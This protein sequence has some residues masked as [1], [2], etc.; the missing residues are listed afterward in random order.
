[1]IRFYIKQILINTFSEWILWIIRLLKNFRTYHRLNIRICAGTKVIQSQ[2][3]GN[4]YI[5]PHA[6]LNQVE[7]GRFSY[8]AHS[9]RIS[10]AQIGRFCSIGM[11]VL[12]GPGRHPTHFISSHPFF[13]S[14]HHEANQC[15]SHDGG[16][17][18]T[19]RVTIGHDVWIGAKCI[20]LDGV[21]IGHG[22]IIA[23]GA[24]VTKDIPPYTIAAGIPAKPFRT[25]FDNEKV[26]QLLK[27]PWWDKDISEL[28]ALS[29]QMCNPDL[30]F[31]KDQPEKV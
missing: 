10:N 30:F 12:I 25:R 29:Q 27:S 6:V 26:D 16:F 20:V 24:V 23:A 2:L 7:L 5:G 18:E 13:Y 8:V 4:N 9:T 28:K 22:A 19:N 11:Q 3:E 17:E 1:V 31:G 14:P 15:N 21:T